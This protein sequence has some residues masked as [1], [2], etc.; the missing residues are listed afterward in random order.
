MENRKFMQSCKAANISD[1]DLCLSS[2]AFLNSEELKE[3]IDFRR[4]GTMAD[5]GINAALNYKYEETLKKI[6]HSG[7][8]IARLLL[9]IEF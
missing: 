9:I 7:T 1:F 5:D 4:I 2:L 3:R 6:N 8:D